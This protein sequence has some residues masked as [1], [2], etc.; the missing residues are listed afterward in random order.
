MYGVIGMAAKNRLVPIIIICLVLCVCGSAAFAQPVTVIGGVAEIDMRWQE[1]ELSADSADYTVLASRA[2]VGF[3][4]GHTASL[5][6][7]RRGAL[8]RIY[9]ERISART[10]RAREVVVLDNNAGRTRVRPRSYLPDERIEIQGT[11]LAVNPPEIDIITDTGEFAVDVGPGSVVRRYIYVTDLTDVH[12]GDRVGVY[13]TVRGPRIAAQRVQVLDPGSDYRPLYL[14][15]REDVVEGEV[16]VPTSSFDRAIVLATDFGDQKV[17]VKKGA[18]VVRHGS[19]ISVHGL[20]RGELVRAYGVWDSGALSATKVEAIR[21]EDRSAAAQQPA[22]I[23]SPD[24]APAAS[25]DAVPVKLVPGEHTGRIV[26]IDPEGGKITVDVDMT[27]VVVDVR[28]AKITKDGS[29]LVFSDLK[30]GDKV[31]VAGEPRDGVFAAESV[32]VVE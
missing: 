19:P 31:T 30:K 22:I 12:E 32:R 11:V 29:A 18:E 1:F 9:G 21:W 26:D 2:K 4:D 20:E 10:V 27:D 6:D 28:E 25:K 13:G 15:R 23:Q 14:E 24:A 7:L 17:D 8:V 3:A 5:G 16:I